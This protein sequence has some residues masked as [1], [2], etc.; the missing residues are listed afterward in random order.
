MRLPNL[1]THR[2]TLL[3]RTLCALLRLFPAQ[4]CLYALQDLGVFAKVWIISALA[5]LLN[6][7]SLHCGLLSHLEIVFVL[8]D[9]GNIQIANE[10][11]MEF[12]GLK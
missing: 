11:V 7:H 6:P 1:S 8:T 3:A 10:S 4:L 5:V 12:K 2:L 9:D